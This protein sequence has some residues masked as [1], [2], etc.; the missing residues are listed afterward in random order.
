MDIFRYDMAVNMCT[1]VK[2]EEKKY[3]YSF[4]N[5]SS[6]NQL[7]CCLFSRIGQFKAN[8]NIA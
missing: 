1:F 3:F 8:Y 6:T 7:F 5:F 2:L 4:E